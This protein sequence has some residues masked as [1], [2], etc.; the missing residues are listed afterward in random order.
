MPRSRQG[1]CPALQREQVA[2][3]EP[4]QAELLARAQLVQV[5]QLARVRRARRVPVGPLAREQDLLFLNVRQG[6]KRTIVVVLGLQT[7]Q[8]LKDGNEMGLEVLLYGANL[9]TIFA[10]PSCLLSRLR[11]RYLLIVV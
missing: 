1:E 4:G 10:V 8:I 2:L 5:Q 7:W 3:L 9:R 11:Q 6:V